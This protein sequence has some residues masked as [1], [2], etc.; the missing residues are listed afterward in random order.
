MAKKAKEQITI[1]IDADA[2]KI[3]DRIRNKIGLSRSEMCSN[4]VIMGL[5]DARLLDGIGLV[6][7]AG[8]IRSLLDGY[9][10]TTGKN[11]KA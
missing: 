3:V 10:K 9:K 11:E 4:L 5:D 2:L 1:Q 6:S 7:I 8:Y